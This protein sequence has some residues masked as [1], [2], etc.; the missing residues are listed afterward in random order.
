MQA[1]QLLLRARAAQSSRIAS[2]GNDTLLSEG[3]G[4]VLADNTSGLQRG[5]HR[6]QRRTGSLLPEMELRAGEV[7][8][9]GTQPVAGATKRIDIWEGEYL[10]KEKV[11]IK[12]I[13]G[14]SN[15]AETMKV[16][17]KKKKNFSLSFY[18]VEWIT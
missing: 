16:S 10:G 15:N 4:G 8:R 3:N 2:G 9:I 1:I 18:A 11:A 13:R 12:L 14:V 5:L 6:L 7:R 17:T